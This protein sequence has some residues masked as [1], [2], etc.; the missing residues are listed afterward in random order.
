MHNIF[1]MYGSYIWHI[2]M[3]NKIDVCSYFKVGMIRSW[4]WWR[5]KVGSWIYEFRGWGMV[6]L[7]FL[8][9][10]WDLKTWNYVKSPV[11]E[12]RWWKPWI[13]EC[14]G[15]LR[16]TRWEVSKRAWEGERWK[17]WMRRKEWEEWAW[18][19]EAGETEPGWSWGVSGEGVFWEAE[20]TR[21]F[22]KE[23]ANN[24]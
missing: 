8:A 23:G 13:W 6:L 24:C 15:E 3:Y 20:W 11:Y 14:C 9:F 10:K 19:G 18:E 4:F 17:E 5:Y 22:K 12:Y 16:S 21:C 7:G 2:T 1:N